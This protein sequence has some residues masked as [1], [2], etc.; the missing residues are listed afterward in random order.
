MYPRIMLKVA[1]LAGL[2]FLRLLALVSWW[3]TVGSVVVVVDLADDG[4]DKSGRVVA[5][6]LIDDMSNTSF[7][8][9]AKY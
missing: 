9:L 6:S 5:S 8:F 4:G 3:L 1:Y 7:S 2:R